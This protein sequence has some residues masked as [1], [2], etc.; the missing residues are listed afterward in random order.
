MCRLVGFVSRTPRTLAEVLGE[1]GL[2][3]LT[4]LSHQHAD[5]W[6]LAW[7]EGGEVRRVASHLPAH[8]TPAY[9]DAV[10]EVRTDAA[11]LHLRWATP[12]LAVTPAN[13]H[14]FVVGD[15]AFGHNGAVR[16]GDGLLDLLDRDQVA[17]LRGD[18][19]SERLLHVLLDRI[20]AHGLDAGLRRAVDDVCAELTPS[21]LNALLLS[22]DE[23]TAVCCH[24]APSLGD[25]PVPDGP[26][27]DQPGY[28]DLRWRQEG[29]IVLI[30]S[31]PLGAAGWQRLPN[32]S[33]LVV[34]RRPVAVRR[35]EVGGLPPAALA[36]ERARRAATTVGAP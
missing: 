13:T 7:T 16:P 9:A 12:G 33:A 34:Q 28:F 5:G 8:A 17:R 6:G 22:P 20:D 2:A 21:S 24:G 15:R 3:E 29:D 26:P 35:L 32:G 31:E 11:L 27:E 14:P 36:R 25:P 10:R 1:D 23:L 18:T 19:D 30:A 4:A